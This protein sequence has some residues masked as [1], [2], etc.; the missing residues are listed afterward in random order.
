MKND[1]SVNSL[2]LKEIANS[3]PLK[4]DDEHMLFKEYQTA[5][6]YRKKLIKKIIIRSNL[7]FVLD[8]A[9]CF[10]NIN[11]VNIQDLFSEGKIG[12]LLSFDKFDKTSNLRFISYSVW[13]I[14]SRITKFLE[15]N[16]LIRIPSHQKTK[17]IKARKL[18]DSSDFDNDV[19]YLHELTGNH[20][21]LDDRLKDGTLSVSEII[22]DEKSE[23]VDVT[24]LNNK[25]K[26]KLV[27]FIS[28]I[29]KEEEM[30][31]IS[32]LYGI[33]T[34]NPLPLRDVKDIIGKSHERVRQIRDNAL[35]TLR[36]SCCDVESFKELLYNM[37]NN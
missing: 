32:N 15:Q 23:A 29:L 11:G 20:I 16:D 17:L 6:E 26:D 30:V 10:K 9:L 2:M 37:N 33:G 35:R 31:V 19:Y 22:S 14:R 1:L 21:S 18:K 12:L 24:H 27:N 4:R 28:K 8:V 3:H 5:S 34:G 36:K 13:W 7:R 25:L